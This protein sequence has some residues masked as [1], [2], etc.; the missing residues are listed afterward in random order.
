VCA[1]DANVYLAARGKERAAIK[2]RGNKQ[3]WRLA[4]W[5]I[6]TRCLSRSMCSLDK[7]SH[8]ERTQIIDSRQRAICL[9]AAAEAA[10]THA[11]SFI[12]V[13]VCL[14]GRNTDLPLYLIN[15]TRFIAACYCFLA[16]VHRR[17][18]L[19]T[20]GLPGARVTRIKG[21]G[22]RCSAALST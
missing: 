2:T 4:R 6:K 9:V 14:W 5:Q 12:F 15:F 19:S 18:Y 16:R 11:A 17:E 13:H 7:N 10:R 8:R 1:R 20:L 21:I 22:W 3:N